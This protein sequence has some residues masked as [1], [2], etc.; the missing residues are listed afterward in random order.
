VRTLALTPV[1]VALTVCFADARQFTMP[2]VPAGPELHGDLSSPVW[3]Q[4]VKLGDFVATDEVSKPQAPTEV[5]A[6]CDAEHLYVAF[7]C[8][9]PLMGQLVT[10]TSGHD[11]P[12]VT[13]DCVELALDVTNGKVQVYN[14]IANSRGIIWDALH[15]PTGGGWRWDSAATAKCS[16]QDDRWVCEL[17]I[18]FDD[19]GAKPQP[20]EVWGLNFCRTRRAGGQELNSWCPAQSG[21]AD[22]DNFGEARFAPSPGK[23]RISVLSRGGVSADADE[24]RPN[25]FSVLADNGGPGSATVRL[26]MSMDGET[27]V[28]KEAVVAA[29]RSETLQLPYMV[30][31]PGQPVFGFRV[32]V[33]GEQRYQ[34]ELRAVEPTYRGPRSW[35]LSDPLFEEVLSDEPPGLRR[36]GVLIWGHLNDVSLLRETAKRFAVR[37]TEDEAYREHGL[38]G[39]HLIGHAVR[40]RVPGDPWTRWNVTNVPVSPQTA[41]EVSW[42]LDPRSID[43]HIEFMEKVLTMSHPLVWGLFAGDELDG[44]ALRQGAQLMAKPGDYSY[45][46][47]ADEEV[48][49]E[50]GGGKWGIPAGIREQDP[51]PYKWIAYRRWCN[52]KMRQRHRRLHELVRRYEPDMPIVSADAEGG[53]HPYEWS[54]QAEYFDIFT[55]QYAPRG[56]PWRAEVGCMSKIISDLTG[57]EFWPAAHVENY[58]IAPTP[59]ETVE[60]LSQVF[61]NGGSG[62]HFFLPDTAN[63]PKLV[64]DTRSCY[65]GSPR[66]WHTLMNLV[67]L[68]RSMP[69]PKYPEYER[70]AVLFN[71]DTLAATPYDAERPYAENTEACYT[72]LGP[73][74]RSWFRFVDCA[75][76]I[77]WPALRDRFDIIYVPAARYQRTEVVSK[78]RAFVAAGGTLICGDCHAFE[79]DI[80]GN[81]TVSARTELFGVTVGDKLAV[82]KLAPGAAGL[83]EELPLYGDAYSLTPGAQVEVMATYED[84]SPAITANSLGRGRAILFGSNPFSLTA[85]ADSD[86]RSFFTNWV[87]ATG[88]PTGLDIWRFEFPRSVIW[89]ELQQPGFCLT[90]NRVVWQ[91][92]KPHYLQNRA[93]GATY[94]YSPAPD[95]MPDIAAAGD[96]IPCAEGHLTD[97]RKAIKARKVAPYRSAPYELPASRW[98]VGWEITDAVSVTFDLQKPW[99]PLEVKL[100]FCDTMPA[101]T[102]EGSRDGQQWQPLGSAPPDEAG[103][104]VYDMVIPLDQA[105]ACRHLRVNFATRQAGQKLTL[106]EVEVWGDELDEH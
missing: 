59:E 38:H 86:W 69:I 71:D 78:L 48:R 33:D 82:T 2:V 8:H 95:A 75:Q 3:Q 16:V 44:H 76:V 41:P 31:Y 84:G 100:W 22:P 66:R 25:L 58:R 81:D 13:D 6:I 1:V 104:D 57:K 79:T 70:T 88:A 18:P 10:E 49:Q 68:L 91:E 106:V 26:E 23:V 32:L 62:L 105:L 93:V 28:T 97:R 14:W 60:E 94:Q 21:F 12:V 27:V 30:P 101:V 53:L 37:Y 96:A 5:L 83:G 15:C 46:K 55:A 103:E 24:Q 7:I 77:A 20:G 64:G 11:G 74:A 51:N 43:Y 73:V 92:E 9:E 67:D 52:A 50:Y 87:E 47:Q 35:V 102:V 40:Q 99:T 61:R 36:E 89:E 72:T 56:N 42:I 39:L 4:A 34:S 19:V 65:F 63:G 17:R 80:L 54:S 45:I 98:M 90:N 29:G 85:I